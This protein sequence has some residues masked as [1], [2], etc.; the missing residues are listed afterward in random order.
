MATQIV[1]RIKD[2]WRH[3]FHG[4]ELL[5]LIHP[6]EPPRVVKLASVQHGDELPRDCDEVLGLAPGWVN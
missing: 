4:A 6:D 3:V 1:A 5:L 2:G